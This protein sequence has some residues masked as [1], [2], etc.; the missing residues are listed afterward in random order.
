MSYQSNL[1]GDGYQSNLTGDEVVRRLNLVLSLEQDLRNLNTAAFELI[2]IGVINKDNNNSYKIQAD[3]YNRCLEV[4]NNEKIPI[5]KAALN[6]DTVTFVSAMI[7]DGTRFCGFFHK[8]GTSLTHYTCNV[9]DSGGNIYVC[10]EQSKLVSGE[11]IK[12]INGTSLLGSGDI[13]IDF[14]IDDIEEIRQGAKLGETSTQGVEV[15]VGTLHTNSDGQYYFYN[16]NT[17]LYEKSLYEKAEDA[18]NNNKIPVLKIDIWESYV[19][20]T[21]NG[22]KYVGNGVSNHHGYQYVYMVELK[23]YEDKLTYL[24]FISEHQDISGKQDAISDLSV[25]REN[26]ALGATALQK[27]ALD[28]YYTKDEMSSIISEKDI[29]WNDVI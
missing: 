17:N 26:A 27:E 19:L 10:K 7:Y 14:T 8:G 18:Y 21:K 2:D 13:T 9:L 20:L 15:F 6:N 3:V 23:Q 28:D 24:P 11:N 4:W 29:T 16:Y 22:N 12:T 25:I 1:T 5:L